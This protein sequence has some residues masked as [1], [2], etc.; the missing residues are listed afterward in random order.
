MSLHRLAIFLKD[1][2]NEIIDYWIWQNKIWYVRIISK[3]S[4]ILYMVKVNDYDLHIDTFKSFEKTKCFYM[5]REHHDENIPETLLQFYEQFLLTFPDQKGRVLLHYSDYMLESR[6]TIYRLMN[7]C[8]NDR[9][10]IHFY[11]TIEWFYE[12]IYIVHHEFEKIYET[13][14]QQIQK[15]YQIFLEKFHDMIR[16]DS[17]SIH[18]GWSSIEQY[19][20]LLK[21]SRAYFIQIGTFEDE[22]HRSLHS[23]LTITSRDEPYF[24]FRETVKRSYE[25]KQWQEKLQSIESIKKKMVEK[26]LFLYQQKNHLIFSIFLYVSRMNVLLTS[27]QTH[28]IDFENKFKS[29]L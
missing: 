8:A 19:H 3:Q 10:Q 9:I 18:S 29:I 2:F 24:G 13:I 7:S 23:L 25:K 5:E 17:R 4:G 15:M 27:I 20:L 6:D 22:C 11:V 1:N 28:I 21:K 26:I 16:Y 12:N 14:S